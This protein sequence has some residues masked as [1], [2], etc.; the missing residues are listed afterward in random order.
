MSKALEPGMCSEDTTT[1]KGGEKRMTEEKITYKD[2]LIIK[3]VSER[4][5]MAVFAGRLKDLSEF[6]I[7]GTFDSELLRVPS[8]K[9]LNKIARYAWEHRDTEDLGF[10]GSDIMDYGVESDC[11]YSEFERMCKEGEATWP[12]HYEESPNHG[13]YLKEAEQDPG[14]PEDPKI[15]GDWDDLESLSEKELEDRIA[16]IGKKRGK[17]ESALKSLAGEFGKEYDDLLPLEGDE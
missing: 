16:E 9:W 4:Y 12:Y 8:E 6:S 2:E 14:W 1:V 5:Q 17:L 10:S 11:A 7:R 13:I 3:Y 15:E